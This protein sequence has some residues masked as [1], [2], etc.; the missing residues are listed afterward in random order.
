MSKQP[1]TPQTT[2]SPEYIKDRE[3]IDNLAKNMQNQILQLNKQLTEIQ[4]TDFKLAINEPSNA[5]QPLPTGKKAWMLWIK[6]LGWFKIRL[7]RKK[8]FFSSLFKNVTKKA[9]A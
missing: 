5:K 3:K 6:L 1:H 7:D 8:I 2:Y 4:I 9:K